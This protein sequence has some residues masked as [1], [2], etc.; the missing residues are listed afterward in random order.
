MLQ[1]YQ[2]A[3]QIVKE[4]NS[5]RR[6]AYERSYNKVNKVD[7]VAFVPGD[8]ILIKRE[9]YPVGV[10]KKLCKRWLGPYSVLKVCGEN[11]VV[12]DPLRKNKTQ[13]IHVN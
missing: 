2:T 6:D 3:Q 5:K 9:A 11:L 7:A 10:N 13:V 1:R 12:D 8:K 4:N